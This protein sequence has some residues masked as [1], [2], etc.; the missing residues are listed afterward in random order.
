MREVYFIQSNC[1][2]QIQV[3]DPYKRVQASYIYKQ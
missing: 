3:S 2:V 1:R